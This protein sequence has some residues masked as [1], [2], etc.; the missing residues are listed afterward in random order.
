M[1][2]VY[3]LVYP[4]DWTGMQFL[5]ILGDMQTGRFF[6]GWKR[7]LA[8]AVLALSLVLGL[9]HTSAAADVSIAM[10]SKQ[11][12]DRTP[13]IGAGGISCTYKRVSGP[14]GFG[15]DMLLWGGRGFGGGEGQVKMGFTAATGVLNGNHMRC[16]LNMGGFTL[17]NGWRPDPL[18]KWRAVFG[19]GSYDLTSSLTMR[20]I[21]RGSFAY[22]TP[23]LVGRRPLSRHISIEVAGGYTFTNTNGVSIGGWCLETDILLGRF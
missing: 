2:L 4:G 18:F 16:N 22:F 10:E 15:G 17:E 7:A 11:P 1:S 19:G 13:Q 20:S 14:Y 3:P 21:N 8:G 12:F 6:L 5:P 23:M 9:A